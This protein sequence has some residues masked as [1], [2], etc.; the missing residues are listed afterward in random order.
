MP[1]QQRC[2]LIW[3]MK[4]YAFVLSNPYTTIYTYVYI[5]YMLYHL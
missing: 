4:V 1:E 3:K 2:D 5:S